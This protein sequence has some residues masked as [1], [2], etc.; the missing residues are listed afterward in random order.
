MKIIDWDSISENRALSNRRARI[1]LSPKFLTSEAGF[2]MIELLMVCAILGILVSLT[3][4]QFLKFRVQIK[5]TTAVSEIRSIEKS[6]FAHLADNQDYPNS[7]NDINL[8]DWRDPWDQPYQY[9]NK[10]NNPGAMRQGQFLT[11]LNSDFDIYSLGPDGVTT[12]VIKDAEGL[13]DIVRTAE[14]GWVGT[15]IDF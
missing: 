15:G 1:W 13:D 2:T 8:G 9:L 5:V 3:I 10:S 4:P 11:D 12:Q 14:G 6:V 7:L